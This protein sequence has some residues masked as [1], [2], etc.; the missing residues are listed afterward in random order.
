MSLGLWV[1]IW[2]T[3][4]ILSIV[5]T[6]SMAG[7]LARDAPPD[8]HRESTELGQLG[9]IHVIERCT[10]IDNSSSST[11]RLRFL[12]RS[13]KSFWRSQVAATVS[14]DHCRDHFGT[15]YQQLSFSLVQCHTYH[16]RINMSTRSW[17]MLRVKLTSYVFLCWVTSVTTYV[18]LCL[19][20]SYQ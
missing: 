12:A 2:T 17:L 10:N 19:I 4:L 20:S 6:S 8:N 9:Q 11:G 7:V 14:H 1:W 13:L 16:N 18:E 15:W 3:V 5:M